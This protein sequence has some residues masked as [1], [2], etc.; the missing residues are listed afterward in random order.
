MVCFTTKT[1]KTSLKVFAVFIVSLSKVMRELVAFNHTSSRTIIID[2]FY[3]TLTFIT[4]LLRFY[5]RSHIRTNVPQDK[6]QSLSALTL[7]IGL[8]YYLYINASNIAPSGRLIESHRVITANLNYFAIRV[9][10]LSLLNLNLL[11]KSLT[12]E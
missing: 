7:L 3:L 6:I 9:L 12:L 2:T 10:S 1:E 5:F 4:A 8:K 11:T